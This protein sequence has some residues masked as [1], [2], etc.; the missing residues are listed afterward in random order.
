MPPL[1]LLGEFEDEIGD[2]EEYKNDDSTGGLESQ[3]FDIFWVIGPN[4]KKIISF[5]KEFFILKFEI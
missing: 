3:D 1:I 2:N 4:L 5:L